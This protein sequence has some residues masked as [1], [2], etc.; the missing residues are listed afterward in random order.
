M[1]GKDPFHQAMQLILIVGRP[2]PKGRKGMGGEGRSRPEAMSRHEV[3]SY[4]EWAD[5]GTRY[6]EAEIVMD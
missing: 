4:S 1:D 6:Q 3:R 2:P 5:R